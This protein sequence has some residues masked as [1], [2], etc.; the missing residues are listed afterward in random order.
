MRLV[1]AALVAAL[2]MLAPESW[3][4]GDA[5]W[6]GDGGYRSRAG[7]LCCGE[8]DCHVV[9]PQDVQLRGYDYH[10]TVAG[11]TYVVPEDQALDSMD[12]RYWA[13]IWGS[14]LKCLFRPR[15]GA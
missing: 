10:V 2:L 15:L 5:K 11:K 4:H 13:C 8:R 7:E 1:F 14:G 3:A 6:I 9:P 12:E